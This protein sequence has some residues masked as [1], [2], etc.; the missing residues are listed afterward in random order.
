M[1]VSSRRGVFGGAL[2]FAAK[3]AVEQALQAGRRFAYGI[4][5][6]RRG[7]RVSSSASV[8]I[9]CRA[10]AA[11]NIATRISPLPDHIF[12]FMYENSMHMPCGMCYCQATS[13]W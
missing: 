13:S 4:A 11:A 8:M 6:W 10:L 2:G 9:V 1:V 7:S 3:P 5:R 12:V